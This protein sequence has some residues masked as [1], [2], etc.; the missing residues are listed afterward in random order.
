MVKRV[1]VCFNLENKS[2]A[3]L[4]EKLQ[5]QFGKNLSGGIRNILFAY[6]NGSPSYRSLEVTQ[7]K[8]D[9]GSVL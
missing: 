4:F 3:V 5:D 7:D 2:Q 6:L 9:L 1:Q 8:D